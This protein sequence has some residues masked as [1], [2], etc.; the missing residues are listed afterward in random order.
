M[1]ALMDP[2]S[3]FQELKRRNVYKITVAYG[4]VAWLLIQAA[5]FPFP[6]I[7]SA[8]NESRFGIA[9]EGRRQLTSAHGHS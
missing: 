3:F 8:L 7:E 5:S 2:G 4:V 9:S 6:I 1:F